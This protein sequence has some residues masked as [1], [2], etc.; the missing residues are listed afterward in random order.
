MGAGGD[1]SGDSTDDL[2]FS[3]N[4]RQRVL[5]PRLPGRGGK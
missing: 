2:L 1:E 3:I 5:R 4:R